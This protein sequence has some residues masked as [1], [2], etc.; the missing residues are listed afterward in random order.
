MKYLN[1][2]IKFFILFLVFIF[3]LYFSFPN[4]SDKNSICYYKRYEEINVSG[5]VNTEIDGNFS[6]KIFDVMVFEINN[7]KINGII[8]V[9][10]YGK[11]EI[12]FYDK[13][14]F[15]CKVKNI[16]GNYKKYLENKNIYILCDIKD[17]NYYN[18]NED[19]LL[20]I[21]YKIFNFAYNIKSIII[22]RINNIYDEKY[23]GFLISFLLGDKRFVS[24]RIE[25]LMI[26]AGLSHITS[27]SGFNVNLIIS[28]LYFI[29]V[30]IGIN[31]RKIFYLIIPI[32][33][34]FTI[35]TGFNP[36]VLRAVIMSII[37][38]FIQQV[39][40][41]YDPLSILLFVGYTMLLFN[42]KYV[43][44]ISFLLSFFSTFAIIFIKP[45]VD[46]FIPDRFDFISL[47]ENIS[48]TLSVFIITSPIVFI[49][50]NKLNFLSIINNILVLP[51]ITYLYL[52]A[53]L[54]LIISPI[55]FIT[56]FILDYIF[57]IIGN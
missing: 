11:K 38:L 29:L 3:R 2:I 53:F 37:I 48:S 44:D 39:G 34:F 12:K 35:I 25:N 14:N 19:W 21:K 36:P 56:C 31:R 4:C 20:K 57:L 9:N 50:F 23:S 17:F 47:K 41:P 16:E 27:I 40:R 22:N 30:D 49:F 13:I 1:I 26:N 28:F 55:S 45:K 46:N 42:P 33:I 52:F 54:S 24:K 10:Y 8:K 51:F 6:K 5:I 18:I 43:F 15:L 7:K 32:L